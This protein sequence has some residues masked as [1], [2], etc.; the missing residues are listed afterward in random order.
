MTQLSPL[1][2]KTWPGFK[3]CRTA[4]K[5]RRRKRTRRRRRVITWQKMGGG[6]RLCHCQTRIEGGREER[7]VQQQEPHEQREEPRE[8]RLHRK[9]NSTPLR[10]EHPL[11][12][13][14]VSAASLDVCTL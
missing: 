8:E 7:V 13:P 4:R 2:Q 12:V 5:R 14:L 3:L 9:Q 1:H 11:A 6:G 10:A